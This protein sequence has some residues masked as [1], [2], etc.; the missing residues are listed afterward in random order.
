MCLVFTHKP[1]HDA[2]HHITLVLDIQKLI[3]LFV[4]LS[5]YLFG[6]VSDLLER[7]NAS[8]FGYRLGEFGYGL[9]ILVWMFDSQLVGFGFV[10]NRSELV[11]EVRGH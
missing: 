3:C 10:R 11:G 1:W 4:C 6:I 5:V 8:C 2:S 9:P 7:F